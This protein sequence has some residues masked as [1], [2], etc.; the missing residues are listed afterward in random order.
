VK[1][2]KRVGEESLHFFNCGGVAVCKRFG[3]GVR[4]GVDYEKLRED[5]VFIT[6]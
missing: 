2:L 6:D 5:V 3:L 1:G 4:S